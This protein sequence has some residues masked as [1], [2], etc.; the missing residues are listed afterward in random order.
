MSR[1][2]KFEDLN[3]WQMSRQLVNHIYEIS[4]QGDFQK[5]YGFKDQIRRAGLSIMNNISEGFESQSTK[6]F[7]NYLGYAK[8]S[9]GEVRSMLYVALDLK[10]IDQGT[11]D[12]LYQLTIT[13]SKMLSRFITYLEQFDKQSRVSE[14]LAEYDVQ[15]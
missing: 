12:E 11:F 8:G 6:R 1:I 3:V 7:I 2:Q 9:S 5:D 4:G 14:A 13:I 10:Y 15:G